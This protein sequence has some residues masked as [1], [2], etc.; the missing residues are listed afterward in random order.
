MFSLPNVQVKFP[1]QVEGFALVPADDF[2]IE[3]I[4][5]KLPAW[6][7][8]WRASKPSSAKPSS[9]APL[10]GARTSP[11][12]ADQQRHIRLSQP[13]IDVS[14]F[15]K[16][17]QDAPVWPRPAADVFRHLRCLILG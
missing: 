7:A 17:G 9:R 3:A 11:T 5:K 15:P 12:P 13:F 6:V 1:I 10:S 2:R 16:L 8:S 4:K 14:H